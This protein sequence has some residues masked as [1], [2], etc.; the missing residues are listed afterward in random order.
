L[1][2]GSE[3]GK[4]E[5]VQ[6]ILD[7]SGQPVVHHP[8]EFAK[9]TKL[10]DDVAADNDDLIMARVA[11]FGSWVTP[12]DWE[13]D[14]DLDL[15]IRSFGGELFLRVNEGTRSKPVYGTES[16]QIEVDGK[17]LKVYAHANPVVADWNADGVWDLVVSSGDGSVG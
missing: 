11:S 5:K 9:Y 6:Q 14:G 4:Y 2:R 1:F 15:L 16:V 7:K 13:S 10:K 17:P 3:E 12:V 8:K